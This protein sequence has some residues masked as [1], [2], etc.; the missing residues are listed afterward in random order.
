S[1]F[2]YLLRTHLKSKMAKD[3]SPK[4]ITGKGFDFVAPQNKPMHLDLGRQPAGICFKSL[5]TLSPA[6]R[7]NPFCPTWTAADARL[8]R[9]ASDAHDVE[10]R[11]ALCSDSNCLM[12]KGTARSVFLAPGTWSVSGTQQMGVVS[13]LLWER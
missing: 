1:L 2:P 11:I 8:S 9:L 13:P 5:S 7:A 6:V 10:D 4:L 12:N 3:R